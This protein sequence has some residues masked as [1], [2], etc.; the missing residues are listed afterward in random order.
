MRVMVGMV[1][2]YGCVVSRAHG[3]H[4]HDAFGRQ[5]RD[6]RSI[7]IEDVRRTSLSLSAC[8]TVKSRSSNSTVSR[9][10]APAL[11]SDP[12]AAR[13][14]VQGAGLDSPGRERQGPRLHGLAIRAIRSATSSLDS[15]WTNT[16]FCARNTA[17]GDDRRRS[18]SVC[19]EHWPIGGDDDR[20]ETHIRSDDD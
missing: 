4:R 13:M 1:A 3:G 18:A 16:A 8:E 11:S 9:T 2:G 14:P 10:V 15:R 20:T 6:Y 17:G 5:H 19:S 12:P 7:V